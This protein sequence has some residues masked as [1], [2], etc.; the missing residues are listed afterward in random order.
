MLGALVVA[1]TGLYP[2]LA[3][4]ALTDAIFLKIAR[5]KIYDVSRLIVGEET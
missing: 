2:A 3:M 5:R 1:N 4:G